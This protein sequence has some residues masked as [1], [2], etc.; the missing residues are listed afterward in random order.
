MK[1]KCSIYNMKKDHK[2]ADEY[3]I[4]TGFLLF[5]CL[6]PRKSIMLTKHVYYIQIK[7]RKRLSLLSE[8]R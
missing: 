6:L 7:N 4:Y 5:L 2:G 3:Y 1:L 8:K